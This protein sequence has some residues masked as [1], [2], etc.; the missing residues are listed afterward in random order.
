MRVYRSLSE[1]PA[2][3]AGR[4]L[5]L[6]TFDGVHLGHRRVI[7]SAVERARDRGL[8]STVV[9]FDPHPLRV[10]RPEQPPRLLTTTD[11]KIDLISELGVD[12][13][14]AI[15]FTQELSRQSAEDFSDQVLAGA[16]GARSVSV[17]ANFRFGHGAAGDAALLASRPEF[18]TDVVEL[19]Q[20]G[21]DSISS[22]RIRS[23]LGEGDVARAA[24]LL[25]AP[26]SVVGPVVEGD[27]RGR[28]LGVP[29]ANMEPP[30]DVVVPAPGIYAGIATAAGIPPTPAAISIG[31]RPTFDDAGDLRVEAHL[32]GFEGDLYGGDM[33]LS[34]L[35]RL[36]DEVRFDS[37]EELVDQ[38]KKDVEQAR[39]VT[40]RAGFAGNSVK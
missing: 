26:Y 5:A 33:K 10:L 2:E 11:Q 18:D 38:M 13:L 39:A 1:V 35:D 8:V 9:T 24:D 34:F 12:E 30:A 40:Y 31:V 32:I 25:G 14:V 20:Q 36:R 22:S 28:E 37:A 16:L 6:G 23:L 3:P 27:R 29:T 21:D 15:P 7:G 4:A 17:G 19:V